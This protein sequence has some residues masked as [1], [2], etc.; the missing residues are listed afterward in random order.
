MSAALYFS[1]SMDL[2]LDQLAEEIAPGDPFFAPNLATATPAMRRLVQMGL[3]ERMGVAAN[4]GF[5]PLEKSLWHC[6]AELDLYRQSEEREPARLLD[7]ETMQ[8]LLLAQLLGRPPAS[9]A[10]YL[11]GLGRSPASGDAIPSSPAAWRKALQLAGR[12]AALFREYE[13]SR[14]REHGR[15][16]LAALWLHGRPCFSEYLSDQ[17][18]DGVRHRVADLE[19]WQSELY[20]QVFGPGGLRDALGEQTGVYRYTLPQY[21]QMVSQ[22]ERTEKRDRPTWHLFGLAHI[23]P[24]HRS[25]IQWLAD[26]DATGGN[27]A[28]FRIYALNPCAE[29]WEDALDP[30]SRRRQLQQNL[31]RREKFASWRPLSR[32]EKESLRLQEEILWSESLSEDPEDNALLARW[33]KVG[34]ENIQLWCQVTDYAF[35]G[36][37]REPT[38]EH[39]LATLQASV[40]HRSA[41]LSGEDRRE[42]D[43]SVK[44]LAAPEIHREMEAILGDMLRRFHSDPGLKPDDVALLLPNPQDYGPAIEAVFGSR[45]PGDAGFIPYVRPEAGLPASDPYWRGLSILAD[46]AEGEWGRPQFLALIQNDCCLRKLGLDAED[47]GNLVQAVAS[48]HLFQGD[49][50]ETDAQ[51]RTTPDPHR[52]RIGLR[53]MLLALWM[54]SPS[55]LEDTS[56]KGYLPR[57]VPL[58]D[59]ETLG[60]M[61]RLLDVLEAGLAPFMRSESRSLLSWSESFFAMAEACLSPDDGRAG[62]AALARHLTRW[63]LR[64]GEQDLALAQAEK[65]GTGQASPRGWPKTFFLESLRLA[66]SSSDIAGAPWLSGGVQIGSLDALRG[67]PFRVVYVAGLQE[68]DFPDEPL[69]NSLDLRQFR[70]VIGDLEPASRN[71]YALLM[72]L[73]Q[74]GEAVILSYVDRDLER[75]RLQQKSSAL[76]ELIDFLESDILPPLD[77]TSGRRNAFRLQPV[78]LNPLSALPPSPFPGDRKLAAIWNAPS[79]PSHLEPDPP[80]KA[81]TDFTAAPNEP[82]HD[83]DLDLYDIEQFLRYPRRQRLKRRLGLSNRSQQELETEEPYT[84]PAALLRKLPWECLAEAACSG[85]GF[86]FPSV[87]ERRLR[88]ASLNGELPP[89]L[90]GDQAREALKTMI[91]RWWEGL[92]T[93][94]GPSWGTAQWQSLRALKM[95]SVR[96]RAPH[97]PP[98]EIP[99]LEIGPWKLHGSQNFVFARE[100]G[101]MGLL[102]ESFGKFSWPQILRPWLIGNAALLAGHPMRAWLEKGPL[103]AW[104]FPAAGKPEKPRCYRFALEADEA[105][106]WMERIA[107]TLVADQ[108]SPLNPVGPDLGL[109]EKAL[110]ID[111]PPFP[112]Q[113]AEGEA[114]RFRHLVMRRSAQQAFQAEPGQGALAEAANLLPELPL[115]DPVVWARDYFDPILASAQ[116]AREDDE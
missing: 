102:L 106:R 62:E 64:L 93:R 6:L 75:D 74:A 56:Y 85:A 14:V 66:L 50:S 114:E 110:K 41:P 95:G 63:R 103:E 5:Q 77:A 107:K 57:G 99:A 73:M 34:R 109:W 8:A 108:N 97:L 44:I 70:R 87:L 76:G 55:D 37:F 83:A 32:Q 111:K 48:L 112:W 100:G 10:H 39:L 69:Q 28:H 90:F 31:L 35:A 91:S 78:A 104:F 2:L 17:V 47:A 92:V 26:E 68:G 4:L 53:R 15:E 116:P 80:A 18:A 42:Q 71:R 49:V 9:A 72:A 86:D 25:L 60:A 30:S 40:L 65:A 33:G 82:V 20:R 101:G 43:E 29:Y 81:E 51:A 94:L 11:T 98:L 105:S 38:R 24:F 23:S 7:P 3:A 27:P 19:G 45:G 52:F 59:R 113:G 16:G 13:Y 61:A 67:L 36:R 88:R 22:Q 58:L 1:N 89:G 96:L 46:M 54:E 84:L 79:A 12:L 115:L 21:S